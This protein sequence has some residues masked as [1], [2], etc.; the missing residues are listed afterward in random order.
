MS[1]THCLPRHRTTLEGLAAHR[2]EVERQ[3]ERGLHAAHKTHKF[4]N[5]HDPT[6]PI[7]YFFQESHEGLVLFKIYYTQ[8]CRWMRCIGCTLPSTSS[9][10]HIPLDQIMRQTHWLFKQA[11]VVK[12]KPLIRKVIVS[13]QGSMLD[14]ETFSTTALIHLVA[15]C[16]AHFPNMEVLTLESRPEYVEEIELEM[17]ARALNEG[18]TPSTLEIAIGVEVFNEDIRQQIFGKGLPLR[19]LEHLVEMLARHLFRVKCYF[20]FK[21]VPDMTEEEA[22]EDV[23]HAIA[24]LSDLTAR[25]P[26]AEISLHLNPTYVT[27]GTQ[28][29]TAFHNGSYTPPHLINVIRAIKFGERRGIPIF[30]GLNDEGLAI[31]GG[32]FI[33]NG[34][35]ECVRI[36]ES[37][38][39]TQ[40]YRLFDDLPV[41]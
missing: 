16:N 40:N 17:I 26:N 27:A 15:K 9:L 20:M 11:D 24:Y 31:P 28:M 12:Q 14:E 22:I 25:I 35:E 2:L 37:F 36:L 8:A 32:S 6:K 4:D 3:I 19:K 33:R 7:S 34:D 5:D 18:Q 30:V 38:N 41:H 1:H 21:P 10:H 23:Q 13:N 39:Q 29:E